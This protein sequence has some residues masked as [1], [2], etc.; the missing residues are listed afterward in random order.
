MIPRKH[1]EDSGERLLMV[2]LRKSLEKSKVE[3]Y[4]AEDPRSH[5]RVLLMSPRS[6]ST[7]NSSQARPGGFYRLDHFFFVGPIVT[8]A[9]FVTALLRF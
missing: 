6:C 7:R 3:E 9:G 1:V 5:S 4:P 2:Y 8:L